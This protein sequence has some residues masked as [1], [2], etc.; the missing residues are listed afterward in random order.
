MLSVWLWEVIRARKRV[1]PHDT[2]IVIRAHFNLPLVT[3]DF[4]TSV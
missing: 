4:E 3:T 1:Q 2:V